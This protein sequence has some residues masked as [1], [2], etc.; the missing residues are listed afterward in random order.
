MKILSSILLCTALLA[1]QGQQRREQQP[2]REKP[3]AEPAPS[4]TAE[5]K[6]VVTHHKMTLAGKVLS[7]NATTGFLPI[8][9]DQGKLEA[10]MFYVAYTLDNPSAKRPLTF[11]FNGGP[12]SATIW[13]H[14]GCFG[15]K[16]VKMKPNGF[17]PPPPFEWED[18]QNT[19]LDKTD[20]VFVD[21]IGTGYS[22][23][24]N[25]EMGK[26]FWSVSGDIAAFGEFVR[27][28][29]QTNSRWTSPLFLAGESYGTRRAAGLSGY[30]VDH[31]I[32]VNG[33]VLIS[34]VLNFETI[35]FGVGNDLPYILYLPTYAATAAYHHKLVP[36]LEKDPE[37]LQKEVE[38][39]AAGEYNLALQQGDALDP[40]MRKSV[41]ERLASYTGLSQQ[42]IERCNLRGS[43]SL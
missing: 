42:Y 27:L 5:E 37:K 22:R 11:A 43:L 14:M 35:S 1:A 10:R 25:S 28:Y 9:D 13:L 4:A 2:E 24:I 6:P 21:A 15:P 41:V 38:K 23:A 34:T 3:G 29:L 39:F 7:Y 32:A 20:L 18:N 16:R 17:M 26:K 33:V 8:K 30:L 12:G 31:G 40:A 19:I 36:E